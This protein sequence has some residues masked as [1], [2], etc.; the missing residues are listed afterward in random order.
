MC[1]ENAGLIEDDDLKELKKLDARGLP[2]WLL[3]GRVIDR[4]HE[5]ADRVSDVLDAYTPRAQAALSDILLKF[6]ALS[7]DDRSALRPALLATLDAC[8][9][10]HTPDEA[11]YP[12]GLKPPARFIE[13][14]VWLELE[15]QVSLFPSVPPAL[16]RVAT[17]DE[18]FASDTPAVCLLV[19]PARELARRLPER[20]IPLDRHASAAA[21]S[22]LLVVER[23]VG[24]VVVGQAE[25]PG[26][27]SAAA[28]LA[29]AH[30]LG[31]AVARHR[32][33]AERA[34]PGAT[35]RAR[36]SS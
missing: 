33:G 9:S 24:G 1:G 19:L 28:A 2:F 35:R 10:L 11:R 30:Q 23:R 21:A 20:S 17:I 14:N 26:R 22:R 8:T 4:N 6:E 15:R 29:Q 31:L 18:L 3:H 16:P 25:Q 27:S 34:A 13:R 32:I 5:D 12:S 36:A 7:E